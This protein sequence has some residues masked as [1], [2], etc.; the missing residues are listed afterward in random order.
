MTPTFNAGVRDRRDSRR[1][2][3]HLRSPFRSF[4][5]PPWRETIRPRSTDLKPKRRPLGRNP[6]ENNDHERDRRDN[7]TKDGQHLRIARGSGRLMAFQSLLARGP[8]AYRRGRAGGITLVDGPNLLWVF[9]VMTVGL[10]FGSQAGLLTA[11]ALAALV[12]Y[13]WRQHRRG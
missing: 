2:G 7:P 9:G 1:D 3:T 5:A 4:V 13:R 12:F 8:P 10:L 6:I 11:A